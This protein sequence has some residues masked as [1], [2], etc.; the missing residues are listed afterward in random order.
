MSQNAFLLQG[1]IV[2]F[3]DYLRGQKIASLP[4]SAWQFHRQP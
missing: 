4:N 1:P 2:L 3:S